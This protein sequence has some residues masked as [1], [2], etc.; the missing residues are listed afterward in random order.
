LRTDTTPSCDT[1]SV[2]AWLIDGARSAQNPDEVLTELCERLSSCGIPLWRVAVFVHTLHPQ[3][4]ARRFLWRPGETTRIAE[5]AFERGDTEEFRQSPVVLINKTGVAIRR[6][7]VKPDC[8]MDFEILHELKAEAV[9]DYLATPLFFTNGEIQAA[10]WT[11]REEGGFT[12]AQI[13]GIEAIVAPLA[14]VAE[15]RALRRTAVNLLDAYVGHAAGE[16]IL[17]GQ[18]RRGDTQSIHAAIWLSDMR[19]FTALADTMAPHALIALLNRFFDCQVPPI[20]AHGGEVLKFMGD[21]LLG[22]F[23][24]AAEAEAGK[25]CVQ[26]LSAAREAQAAIMAMN[27]EG[28]C[29]HQGQIRF[30][31]AL[32]LGEALYGNIGGGGRLDFT[33]IGPAVNMAARLEKLAGRLRR[34]ILAS[35][36][37]ARHLPGE[38]VKLGDYS[39]Q[40]FRA[41]VPVFGLCRE[42]SPAK[43]AE[44]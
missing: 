6:R 1:S 32:H 29:G 9:T 14:R 5:A 16:R 10:T 40:G 43:L 44:D 8:P 36:E 18:I 21:G 38:F 26:A 22:I 25:I 2:A 19:G 15:V 39:L 33:C 31:L 35:F 11:T 4:L 3:I 24:I 20:L 23:P 13:A 41:E 37:F 17:K 34:M 30:G 42:G 12:D 27:E 28:S 7:L